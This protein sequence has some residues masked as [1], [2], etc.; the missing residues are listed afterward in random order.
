M[1][2][3]DT[4]LLMTAA[5]E[6]GKPFN[7]LIVDD[8][9]WVREVFRDYCDLTSAISV[10]I[11]QSGSEAMSKVQSTDYDLMTLDLIMPDMSGLDVLEAVKKIAPKLPVMIVT[12]NAT[13][14]LVNEAGVMGARGV[15][16]KPVT[17][18]GFLAELTSALMK[19][20]IA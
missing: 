7:V 6:R 17:I 1:Q 13:D 14:K 2:K 4:H 18:D 11:A 19:N 16:Y 20:T 3:I 8:E 9:K 12:G 15:L 5:Q 10:D